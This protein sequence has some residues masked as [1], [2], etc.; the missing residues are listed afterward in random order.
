[1]INERTAS[2]EGRAINERQ[3][4]TRDRDQ[5]GDSDE[6]ERQW[7]TRTVINEDSDQRGQWLKKKTEINEGT[8][9]NEGRLINERD[10][11]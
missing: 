1:M 3:W 5:Q 6:R 7:L 2:K 11:D 4:L 9:S 8:A 10:K